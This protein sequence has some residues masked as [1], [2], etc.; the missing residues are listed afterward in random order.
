MN[1]LEKM[2]SSASTQMH[3][4]FINV[5]EKISFMHKF[6]DQDSILNIENRT[7]DNKFSMKSITGMKKG[8][9]TSLMAHELCQY[10]TL[11][12]P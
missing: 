1:L 9:Y 7:L 5:Y 3:L 6:F 10:I 11:Q 4:D 12:H 8:Q 2:K